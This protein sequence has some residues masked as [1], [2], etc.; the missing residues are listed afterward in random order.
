MLS[1]QLLFWISA[2][3]AFSLII[4]K[5]DKLIAK[6][7][8]DKA[9]TPARL[10]QASDRL[11]EEGENTRKNDEKCILLELQMKATKKR[12]QRILAEEIEKLQLEHQQLESEI[13]SKHTAQMAAFKVE[14]VSIAQETDARIQTLEE[15]NIWHK[16]DKDAKMTALKI[17]HAEILQQA[18]ATFADQLKA[19][20]QVGIQLKKERDTLAKELARTAKALEKEKAEHKQKGSGAEKETARIICDLQASLATAGR[21]VQEWRTEA[22]IAIVRRMPPSPRGISL[23]SMDSRNFPLSDQMSAPPSNLPA[24]TPLSFPVGPCGYLNVV[25][26]LHPSLP[27]GDHVAPND[28][29]GPVSSFSNSPPAPAGLNPNASEFSATKGIS[30]T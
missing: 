8:K 30:A 26:N 2:I 13:L 7:I 16:N 12:F 15:E 21:E 25:S 18:S 29:A 6:L 24:A 1:E 3:L 19:V 5:R 11:A 28:H 20:Q 22:Y 4:S 14:H 10:I 27:L 23:F 17:D 9:A